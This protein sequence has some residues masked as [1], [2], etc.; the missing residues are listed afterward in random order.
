VVSHGKMLSVCVYSC[1]RC[2]LMLSSLSISFIIVSLIVEYS[3]SGQSD[4]NFYPDLVLILTMSMERQQ[5]R[6]MVDAV[7]NCKLRMEK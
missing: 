4:V 1:T 5:R 6:M 2:I 3:W 7:D